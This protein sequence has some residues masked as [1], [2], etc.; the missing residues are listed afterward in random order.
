[1]NDGL[2]MFT[3]Y[4]RPRDYPEGYVVRRS[5]VNAGMVWL[6]RVAQYAPA[7]E[8]ARGLIPPGLH[9][10]PRYENDDPCIVEVWL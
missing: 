7:L 9:R 1:V 2:P 8:A 10:I 6:D 3:I 4:E 5:F